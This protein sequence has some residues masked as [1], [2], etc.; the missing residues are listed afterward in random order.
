MSRRRTAAVV[1]GDVEKIKAMLARNMTTK[2]MAFDL[3][4]SRSY[5]DKRVRML[6]YKNMMLSP[7]EIGAIERLRRAGKN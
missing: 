5:V 3:G 6:G 2:E 1:A 4:L 7:F